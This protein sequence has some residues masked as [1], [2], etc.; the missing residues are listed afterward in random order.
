MGVCSIALGIVPNFFIYI[1]FM[2]LFGIVM[3]LLNTPAT[4]LLQQKVEGDYMGR[5]FS[6]LGMISSVMMP[7]G[8]LIFGP[9]ADHLR[10]EYLLV[11]T[12]ILI[13]ILTV[14]FATNKTL[15]KAGES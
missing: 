1:F 10:I 6:I 11:G 12:G 8:M 4:V 3:P 14:F 7:A 13:L 5:I 9:A 2:A 15:V